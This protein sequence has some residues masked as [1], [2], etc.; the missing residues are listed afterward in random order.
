MSDQETLS[1]YRRLDGAKADIK[2]LRRKV[3]RL[4]EMNGRLEHR[5][6][7]LVEQRSPLDEH[8][9]EWPPHA[10]QAMLQDK[11]RLEVDNARMRQALFAR[12]VQLKCNTCHKPFYYEDTEL[13]SEE[14]CRCLGG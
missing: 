11:Q 9:K 12:G 10:V 5:V 1:L 8:L 4:L 2:G 14:C 6:L 7:T 3:N 13:F